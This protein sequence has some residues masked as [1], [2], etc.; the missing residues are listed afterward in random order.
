MA[1]SRNS[2][3]LYALDGGTTTISAFRITVDGHL[4]RIDGAAIPAG[5]A[6]LAAR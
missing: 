4:M 6:G 2:Q 1:L 5:A 3:F